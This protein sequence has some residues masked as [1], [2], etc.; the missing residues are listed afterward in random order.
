M[1]DT[2]N[3]T[4]PKQI[5]VVNEVLK[6]IGVADIPVIHV[7]NKI[8]LLDSLPAERLDNPVYVSAITQRNMDVLIDKID[9]LLY[10]DIHFVNLL[11]PFAEGQI[12]SFLKDHGYVI[13]TEFTEQG[14][15]LK[16]ELT[17]ELYRRYADYIL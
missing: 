14:I 12:Y 8:D 5:E 9:R 3:P 4:F 11:V 6:E 1:I 2:A 10:H 15:A 17:D 13:S 16:A 7:F